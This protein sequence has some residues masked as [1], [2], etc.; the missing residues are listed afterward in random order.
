MNY[1]KQFKSQFD[2]KL[3]KPARKIFYGGLTALLL[4]SQMIPAKI[5][6]IWP[7]T[8][9]DKIEREIKMFESEKPRI[10]NVHV[11]HLY[12]ENND[13]TYMELEGL[14]QVHV[15][16]SKS[17]LFIREPL[18]GEGALGVYVPQEGYWGKNI[19][20]K[21]TDTTNGKNY[22]LSE[23]QVA[24]LTQVDST[25]SYLGKPQPSALIFL[26][27][28]GMQLEKLFHPS[29]PGMREYNLQITSNDGL[30]FHSISFKVDY[31]NSS[32]K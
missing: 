29:K 14:A 10:Q 13:G 32:K 26:K 24:D 27:E 5:T 21:L 23:R 18:P 11:H 12:D 15:G 8:E 25:N 9:K 31:S 1:H 20:A 28:Y 6:S 17:T 7:E 2:E 22:L 30:C 16:T 4:S 19:I 3:M